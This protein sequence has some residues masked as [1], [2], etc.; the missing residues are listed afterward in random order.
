MAQTGFFTR[1]DLKK[2]VEPT[3]RKV[4]RDDLPLEHIYRLGEAAVK[5]MNPHAVHPNMPPSGAEEPT[6]YILGEAPGETEDERDEPFVGKAGETL[7]DAIPRGWEEECRFNNCVRTR[8]PNN[9][10]PTQYEIEAFRKSVEQDIELSKPFAI[11]GTGAIPLQW[12]LGESFGQISIC[13]GRRFP[14][15]IGSHECYFYPVHHP[16]YINRVRNDRK[17]GQEECPGTELERAF[18]DDIR[19]V[20][21]ETQTLPFARVVDLKK[22]DE[23]IETYLGDRGDID[24]IF[25]RL[26]NFMVNCKRVGIDIETSKKRP[27]SR[28]A[29]ILTIA[30]GTMDKT[31]A[32]PLDHPDSRFTAS[33]KV[34]LK[35]KLKEF[36]TSKVAKVAHNAIFELEWL[37]Y[38]FGEEVLWS[39]IW[40]C[41]QVQTY[42]LDER[43]GGQS[44]N[45]A[46]AERLGFKLKEQS[47]VDRSMLEFESDEGFAKN[48]T[49]PLTELLLYN[50]RDTKY[51]DAVDQV[52]MRMI[53]EQGLL[54]AYKFHKKRLPTLANAQIKGLEV[55]QVMIKENDK[56]LTDDI[57][58][59]TEELYQ[60]PS[61]KK[62]EAKYGK[63]NP[64]SH[65]Q[66]VVMFRDVLGR[67]EGEQRKSGKYSTKEEVL[68]LMTDEPLA[69]K[70]LE[71]RNRKKLKSTYVEGLSIEAEDTLVYPD[72]NLHTNF[73]STFTT[74]GRLS[75]DDPNLQNFPKRKDEWIRRA[76]TAGVGNVLLAAD[77]GQLEARVIAM[78]SKDPYL[79][80]AIWDDVDVH[81]EWTLKVIKVYPEACIKRYGSAT[82]PKAIK[83]FRGDL[84]TDF[85]FPAFYGSEAAPI[86]AAIENMPLR[87]FMPVYEEFW[88][89]FRG[90]KAWQNRFLD[91]YEKERFTECLTG[92]KR[93]A[94]MSANMV[95]NSAVQGSASDI[96][97]DSMCRLAEYAYEQEI[98]YL[99]PRINIHDDLTFILPKDKVEESLPI[100][101]RFMLKS[102]F[103]WINVPLSIEVSAGPNWFDRKELGVF[104]SDK[105]AA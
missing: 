24:V 86:A 60:L 45:F 62:Y 43:K 35:E 6:V 27:Y 50:A 71:L 29:R 31:I 100:I 101:S 97:V 103:P 87:T 47:N 79:V 73:N 8:P 83:K 28:D 56:K 91:R 2:T 89:V 3:Q 39:S 105:I 85:V 30:I 72:G 88:D 4:K 41:T 94:P 38:N 23:G 48:I 1:T 67:K 16:S 25:E 33:E 57:K 81:M 54:E 5:D 7:R 11:I 55:D 77:Y 58:R 36:L 74:T 18:Q 22:L 34:E 63:F 76:I 104:R 19:R 26:D 78:F 21:D 65:P 37:A 102:P 84:K 44:L 95:I 80:N 12:M 40:H 9:R 59:L 96:V 70:I 66:L 10:T 93:R 52:Q 20:F 32:F 99:A 15:K 17:V 75:S 92:R 13:R 82:D 42:I 98:P 53:R 49:R 90:V 46:T 69:K 14:V 68:S 51:E 61:V 64:G